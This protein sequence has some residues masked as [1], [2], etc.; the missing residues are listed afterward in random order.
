MADELLMGSIFLCLALLLRIWNNPLS[1]WSWSL[2]LGVCLGF[3]YLCKAAMFPLAPILIVALAF[4][5]EMRSPRVRVSRVALAFLGF[6]L[7]AAPW[8]GCLHYKYGRLTFSDSGRINLLWWVSRTVPAMQMQPLDRA[9]GKPDHALRVLMEAPTVYEFDQPIS[10]TYPPWKDPAWWLSGV[11]PGFDL[12]GH[13]RQ[14]TQSCVKLYHIAFHPVF[15]S[16]LVLLIAIALEQRY[17]GGV[18]R[19]TLRGDAFRATWLLTVFSIA[20]LLMYAVLLVEKNYVAVFLLTFSA[21]WLCVLTLVF[22]PFSERLK[23]IISTVVLV[24]TYAFLPEF[25]KSAWLC[26]PAKVA[27]MATTLQPDRRLQEALELRRLGLEPGTRV[28]VVGNYFLGYWARL[29]RVHIVA[30][31]PNNQIPLLRD[32]K[33]FRCALAAFRDAGAEFVIVTV[34]GAPG[35]EH[36]A[37]AIGDIQLLDLRRSALNYYRVD[38]VISVQEHTRPFANQG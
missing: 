28:G 1:G 37:I 13:L 27:G 17:R 20:G 23:V 10:G 35:K 32:P 7:V 11:E 25:V 6:A 29:C 12:V 2:L 38:G 21:A 5:P 8:I 9:L 30:E 31:V 19:F 34:P 3:G 16:F 18:L 33:R 26:L 4:A 14:F 24:F 36:G 15:G 22:R